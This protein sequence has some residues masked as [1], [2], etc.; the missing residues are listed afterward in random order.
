MDESKEDFKLIICG[1]REFNDYEYLKSA[2]DYNL[3]DKRKTHNIIIISG[4]A[5]GAD[6]LGE[7]YAEENNFRL[8]K[9]PAEWD[10]YGK[11]AGHLRN[12]KMAEIANACIGFVVKGVKCPGT[13]N[14]LKIATEKNLLVRR[15][16]Y[17]P[18]GEKTDN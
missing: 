11:R 16:D 12:A 8:I 2:C 10:K 14:M 4:A 13:E 3:Q 18:K 6:S 15:F 9:I 17:I 7:K 5:R 1:S